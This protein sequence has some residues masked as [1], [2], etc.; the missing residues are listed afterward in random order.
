MYCVTPLPAVQLKVAEVLFKVDNGAGLVITAADVVCAPAG[1][2]VAEITTNIVVSS[3]N[4][5]HFLLSDFLASFLLVTSMKRGVAASFELQICPHFIGHFS[6]IRARAIARAEGF[7]LF[8][9][10]L[11]DGPLRMREHLAFSL[12]ANYHQLVVH[13]TG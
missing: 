4:V 11:R 3:E 2:I 6:V 7:R 8:V 1:A 5:W 10:Y 12:I 13:S 9:F